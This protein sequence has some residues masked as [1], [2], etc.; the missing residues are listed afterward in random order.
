MF[1]R[2][3][4][5]KS[6]PLLFL[7]ASVS[8]VWAQVQPDRA[9]LGQKKFRHPG[10]NISRAFRRPNELP[11][12]A[13]GQAAGDLAALGAATNG[14][15]VDVRG[16]RWATLIMARPLIPGKGVGNGL[17]WAGLGRRKP[18][19]V[20]ALGS[21]TADAL[22]AYLQAYAGQLRLDMN[23]IAGSK[24]AVLQDGDL[25]QLYSPRVF[26][27]ISVRGSYLT[28][29]VSKAISFLWG[30]RCGETLM[31]LPRPMALKTTPEL[32]LRPI[33]IHKRSSAAGVRVNWYSSLLR[34]EIIWARHPLVGAIHTAWPGLFLPLSQV[35]RV[36]GRRW[37]TPTAAKCSPSKIQIGIKAPASRAESIRS[38]MT[39]SLPT[40]LNRQAGRCPSTLFP[41]R[42]VLLPPTAV[43]I[44]PALYRGTS[45]RT[46]PVSTS[47]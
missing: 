35:R 29:V 8:S 9:G 14:G 31:S 3:R 25:V 38:P 41:P 16:G 46:S 28:A 44:S 34:V 20:A 40:A 45:R 6:L 30:R 32:P 47:A 33:P 37:S 39:A 1:G 19:T 7:I 22:R 13:A 17:S 11:P 27:R 23:E 5:S 10:L 26:S 2:V 15:R 42:A 43:A 36:I 24:V 12:Q 4:A 21:A 18:S